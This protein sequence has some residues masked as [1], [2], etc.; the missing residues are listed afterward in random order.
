M[1]A[2]GAC[3][4]VGSVG[5]AGNATS[6]SSGWFLADRIGFPFVTVLDNTGVR[7]AE[8]RFPVTTF[9]E[10]NWSADWYAWLA[11][12]EYVTTAKWS[13]IVVAPWNPANVQTELDDLVT[14]A[15]DERADALG[16]I[17]SE[18]DEFMSYF[19]NLLTIRP[20][21][22]PATTRLLHIANLIGLF[23]VMYFKGQFNRPRPSQLCPALAPPVAVPGHASFPSGHATQSELMALCLADVLPV[24]ARV[25]PPAAASLWEEDLKALAHRIARNRE[26]AGLHYPS[27]SHAGR[28]LA[29]SIHV[30]L[31]KLLQLATPAPTV[32][33][34]APPPPYYKFVVDAAKAEWT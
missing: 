33:S 14:A 8:N 6:V 28:E 27:D 18:A 12:N 20:T 7:I 3:G 30:E 11:L 24:V 5:S 25:G 17:L 31:Q 9:P 26:I 29:K 22:H 4:S 34:P 10:R 32:F 23:T 21:S 19:M 16:E 1:V 13:T 2:L 15:Q